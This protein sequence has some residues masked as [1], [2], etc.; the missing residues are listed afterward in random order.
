MKNST[1]VDDIIMTFFFIPL[2]MLNAISPTSMVNIGCF[3]VVKLIL[4]YMVHPK[5]LNLLH[6][7]Y[8][9]L[10]AKMLWKPKEARIL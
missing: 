4:V 7:S 1:N 6:H 9:I 5:S 2:G 10:G 8:D 3:L